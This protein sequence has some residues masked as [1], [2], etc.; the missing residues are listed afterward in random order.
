MNAGCEI[1][2]NLKIKGGTALLRFNWTLHK[3]KKGK[4]LWNDIFFN[5][6]KEERTNVLNIY[7]NVWVSI[8]WNC[9]KRVIICGFEMFYNVYDPKVI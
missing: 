4:F 9:L 5:V 7:D 8:F 1:K 2:Y 3:E 6:Q